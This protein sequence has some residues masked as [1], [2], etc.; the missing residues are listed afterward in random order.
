ML[1]IGHGDLDIFDIIECRN[2]S[3]FDMTIEGERSSALDQT[4]NLCS[5]EVLR[6]GGQLGEVDVVSHNTVVAHLGCVDVEDLEATSLVRQGNLDMNFETA[7]TEKGF[8]DHVHSI[9]HTDNQDIVQLV[10][11][12]HLVVSSVFALVMRQLTFDSS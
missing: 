12:V 5:R 4:T 9:R 10:N 1:E 3:H 7:G 6:E 8:V 11:T 2:R